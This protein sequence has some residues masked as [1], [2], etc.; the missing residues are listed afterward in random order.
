M[1]VSRLVAENNRL[2]SAPQFWFVVIPER[3]YELG[4]PQ[5]T[6]RRVDSVAGTV[7]ISQ[8]RARQLQTKPTLFGDDER[9]AE[10]Y[11]YAT[12]FRRQ[13]KARPLKAQNMGRA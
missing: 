11:Q 10:F 3:V 13:L 4:R 6:V 12:Q 1:F 2:E 5:S 9:E 7:T 8:R